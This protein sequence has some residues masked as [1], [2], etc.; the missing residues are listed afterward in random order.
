MR[1][2]IRPFKVDVADAMGAE[3]ISFE[4]LLGEEE[5]PPARP[6]ASLRELLTEG[7]PCHGGLDALAA[8]ES[9]S[10]PDP[11]MAEVRKGFL[12]MLEAQRRGAKP[13]S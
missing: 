11:R 3:E 1:H 2:Q 6:P 12:Q 8:I 7:F 10:D 13:A 9:M 4:D 5:A